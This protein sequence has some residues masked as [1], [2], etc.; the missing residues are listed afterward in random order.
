MHHTVAMILWTFQQNSE[1]VEFSVTSFDLLDMQ[2]TI[3]TLPS[4]REEIVKKEKTD[5][6][7]EDNN[8]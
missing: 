3:S 8:P 6:K 4:N 7:H 5:E 2:N 1:M